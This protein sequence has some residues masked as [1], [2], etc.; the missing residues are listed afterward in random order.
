MKACFTRK[1]AFSEINDHSGPPGKIKIAAAMHRLLET[2]DFSSI[3]TA[4][5]SKQ[6]GVNESMIYR[7]FN[8]KRGLL[9]YILA[10][11]LEISYKGIIDSLNGLEGAV[12]K[13]TEVTRCTF[14]FYIHNA[15]FAKILFLEVRNFPGYWESDTYQF[16]KRYTQLYRQII[17]E[18]HAAGE[19]RPDI[20]KWHV[21]Q[22]LL[23]TI[24]HMVLPSLIFQR[25][26]DV[27]VC[28]EA[29]YK[30]VLEGL[31]GKR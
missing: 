19:I 6:S 22:A 18:G 28:T 21:M 16:V 30:L 25:P 11:Y 7:Y 31:K 29:V 9:H 15:T 1:L 17:E 23:G 10:Q 8:D 13:L 26:L 14:G 2:K 4:E 12:D 20:E 27:D 5:I 24:E 3:T